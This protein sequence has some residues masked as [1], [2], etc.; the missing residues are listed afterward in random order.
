MASGKHMAEY[1]PDPEQERRDALARR[2]DLIDA[3]GIVV[4]V[5]AVGQDRD[6]QWRYGIPPAMGWVTPEVAAEF[7]NEMQA[8]ITEHADELVADGR[9]SQDQLA[10]VEGHHYATGPAAQEWPQFFF[11]L[12]R[13]ARPIVSDGASLLGWGY[14]LRDFL[15]GLWQ[16]SADKQREQS[17][18]PEDRSVT[19]SGHGSVPGV[20]LTR[21][22]VMALCY[23]HM[24]ERHGAAGDVTLETFPRVAFPGY[25]DPDHP[26]GLETYLVRGTVGR[27]SIF[28][29]VKGN[30]EVLE[31]FVQE[32]KALTLAEL[33]DFVGEPDS[34]FQMGQPV[35]SQRVKVKGQAAESE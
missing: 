28:Y 21:P 10:A 23:A 15:K 26:G 27:R 19:Y 18:N 6:G 22:A 32:G 9:L 11:E 5:P 24:C 35:A 8:L 33:P 17:P 1:R 31:H 29:L 34:G 12:Y 20:K 25:S 16:W 13:D 3:M 30:G 4:V 7:Q 14:F 2:T